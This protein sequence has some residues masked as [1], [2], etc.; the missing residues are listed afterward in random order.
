[1]WNL[2]WM[3]FTNFDKFDEEVEISLLMLVAIGFIQTHVGLKHG[4]SHSIPFHFISFRGRAA[5]AA[6]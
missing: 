6:M 2:S 3:R 4:I 1:M 5:V